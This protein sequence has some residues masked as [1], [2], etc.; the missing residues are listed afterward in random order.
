M[1]LLLIMLDIFF[2]ALCIKYYMGI[3]SVIVI[4]INVICIL[5][6]AANSLR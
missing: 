2:I 6:V 5:I 4:A 1:A 3:L